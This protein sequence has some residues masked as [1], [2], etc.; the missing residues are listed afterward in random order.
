MG[1]PRWVRTF[2]A[3]GAPGAYLGV[4]RPGPVRAGDPITVTHRPGHG[5]TIG[6]AFRA[7]TVE[8]ESLPCLL[9]ADELPAETRDHARR[10]VPIALDE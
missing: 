1:V 4:L 6:L 5:V 9:A 3:H 8:P 10:R 7:L 2:T